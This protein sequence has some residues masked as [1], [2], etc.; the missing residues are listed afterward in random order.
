MAK[1]TSDQVDTI[2]ADLEAGKS[3]G[4]LARRYGVTAGSIAYHAVKWGVVTA[5]SRIMRQP[6]TYRRG[7][8]I[9]RPFT[10]EEDTK[11]LRWRAE[12][13]TYAECGRRFGR[14]VSSVLQRCHNLARREEFDHDDRGSPR[15]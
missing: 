7:N 2:L 6:P 12:G 15:P 9:V 5:R 14:P 13:L 4:Q 8:T 11:L 10:P 3:C 1:L